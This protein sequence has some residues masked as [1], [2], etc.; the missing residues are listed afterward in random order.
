MLEL[1]RGRSGDGLR[2]ASAFELAGDWVAYLVSEADDFER[3]GWLALVNLATDTRWSTARVRRRTGGFG[4]THH[5]VTARGDLAWIR[6]TNDQHGVRQWRL[7]LR[8]DDKVTLRYRSRT[9]LTGL[10]LSA[11]ELRFRER[12]RVRTRSLP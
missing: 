10:V 7:Y 5:A 2:T 11:T 4:I 12:G 1:E 8:R 9:P 3:V 6:G